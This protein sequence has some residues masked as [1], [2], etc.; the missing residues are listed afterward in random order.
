[1][2]SDTNF[3]GH[4]FA[5]TKTDSTPVRIEMV[6]LKKNGRP[7][8]LLP[9]HKHA[10]AATFTLYPAQTAKARFIRSSLQ[11]L[12]RVGIRI[13]SSVQLALSKG[14][15]FINFLS[16]LAD[17]GTVAPSFGVLAGNPAS[18]SQRFMILVFNQQQQPVAVV[19][20]GIN[21]EAR[22]LV[23]RESRFLQSAPA[24]KPGLPRILGTFH[25]DRLNAFALEFY[26]GDSPKSTGRNKVDELL[27]AWVDPSQTA[28][29]QE[30]AE[31]QALERTVAADT[32]AAA[33]CD[34]IR[35]QRIHP[36]LYHG[37]FAPWNIK[38]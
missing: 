14:D 17:S 12:N 33:G 3:W 2:Q 19:K 25:D 5:P 32:R 13:G 31:W 27:S 26:P 23:E 10:A 4:L 22:S 8:L 18:P 28:R 1:M 11:K 21:P 15:G 36:V 7:L 29:L 37:D 9:R 38:A 6:S 30:L 16:G 20:T 35:A 24:N 34:Q